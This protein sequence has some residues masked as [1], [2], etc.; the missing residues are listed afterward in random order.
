MV[1]KT[2]LKVLFSWNNGTLILQ[3]RKPGDLRR[4]Q[5]I[6]RSELRDDFPSDLIDRYVHWL[7]L[8]TGE[9]EFRPVGSLW[10]PEPSNW[11]L[12]M[13]RPGIRSHAVLQKPN[14]G[15]SLIDIHSR[16]FGVVSNAV[17][18]LESP[19]NIV[20]TYTAQM[21]EVFLPR[22]HLSFFLNTNSELECRSMPGYVIDESQTCGTMFG[23]KNKLFLRPTRANSKD[24]LLPRRVIIPQGD[25]SFRKNGNFTSVSINIDGEQHVRWHEYTVDTDLGCLTGN[26]S[27]SSKLYQCYLHALTSHCLPDP[28]L[29]HTGTEEALYILRSASCR[30]FQRLDVHDARLLE[31]ISRLTPER[32]YYPPHLQSMATVKWNDLPA[33]SQHHGF[34]QAACS[35]FDHA[36]A[37]E[38]LYDPPAVFDTSD[39]NPSLL[40]RAASRNR[41]YYPSDLQI[42][43]QPSSSDDLIYG[44][45][46]LS[47]L[48]SAEHVAFQTSWSV[49]NSQPS[50]NASSPT[51]WD[52]MKSWNSLG[53]PDSNV[54]LRYSQ[55]WLKFDAARDWF[56][57]YELCRR[58][59]TTE[60]L[61]N[62][63]IEMCFSLSAAAYSKSKYF[64]LIPFLIIFS[65]DQ[66]FC[67]INPPSGRSYVP[68]HGL[69]P[70][71]TNLEKIVS[72]S[73]L[74]FQSTPAN[75]LPGKMKKKN[76]EY[77][78][79]I[80][81]ESSRV[82]ELVLREWP[83]YQNVDLPE[84][85][86]DKSYFDRSIKEYDQSI[87]WNVRLGVH[88]L[89][90]QNVLNYWK[91]PKVL[92][93]IP[94]PYIFSPQF[95]P[96]NHK[97]PSY[98]LHDIFV[99]RA[100]ISIPPLDGD[101]L[102]VSAIPGAPTAEPLDISDSL[103]TLIEEFRNSRQPL[104]KLYGSELKKSHRELFGQYASLSVR[105]GVSPHKF[106]LVYY[107]KCSQRKD[108]IFSEI[109][110]ALAPSQNVEAASRIAG[111]WPRITPRSLLRQLA[112]DHI[113]TLPSVWRSMI[114]YYAISLLKYRHS[115][116]LLELSSRQQREELLREIETINNDV[117]SES[118]PDWLLIQVCPS[119]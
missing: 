12:Y 73:S 100:N 31:L 53:P 7:D 44:S 106:L 95:I 49:W 62:S 105:G 32:I 79:V 48:G 1:I 5:L 96:N 60:G 18:S 78:G 54:S 89:L 110:A 2:N 115:I 38:V 55:Y 92:I 33:L 19:K 28:L 24:S 21:L 104:L 34:F 8:S 69:A 57:I 86:F 42:W 52:V 13:Q 67:D 113:N 36:R 98:S 112:Q 40:S 71:L 63:K 20:A 30:S 118:S 99:S 87:S 90:L 29:G 16:T 50:F 74:P 77:R 46:D 23:L 22:F 70:G 109:F 83:S 72:E 3:V 108:T 6:P 43:E 68:S 97:P 91:K 80:K 88:I 47:D 85:W 94:V 81:K 93:P 51:L 26:A 75:S 41:S 15:I 119:C 103:D 65:L 117:V 56:I 14:Q 116:R 58:K 101:P 66:R 17:S 4:L 76:K 35:I 9:L 107:H 111:L 64:V 102:R 27:L 61:R 25:I 45:R 11:R 114:T 37:L 84:E 82:A 59:A 39:R 10:T